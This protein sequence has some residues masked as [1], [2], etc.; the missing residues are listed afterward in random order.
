VLGKTRLRQECIALNKPHNRA[1]ARKV[2]FVC[3]RRDNPSRHPVGR[4]ERNE[5]RALI[6]CRPN[7]KSGRV[8]N[9]LNASITRGAKS[10][11]L[12]KSYTRPRIDVPWRDNRPASIEP[13]NI[14][15]GYL[16]INGLNTTLTD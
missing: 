16:R 8:A 15:G 6:Q 4:R 1:L 12:G 3:R 11:D 10:A 5:R 14:I 2:S 9:L 13:F 7:I